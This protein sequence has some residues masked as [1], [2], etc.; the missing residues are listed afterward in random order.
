[1][2]YFASREA[3]VFEILQELGALAVDRRRQRLR[4]QR[5]RRE[6][7]AERSRFIADEVR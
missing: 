4:R 5:R 7:A 1:V 3:I 6:A 2:A